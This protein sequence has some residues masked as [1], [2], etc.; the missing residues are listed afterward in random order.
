MNLS[1]RLLV[2][3]ELVDGAPIDIINPAT[4]EMVCGINEAS[5]E[6]VDEAVEAA[7]CLRTKQ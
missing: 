5:K 2:N 6:Q 3:G 1:T 7:E 4:G